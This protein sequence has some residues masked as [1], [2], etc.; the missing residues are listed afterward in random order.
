MELH[1]GS[2]AICRVKQISIAGRGGTEPRHT[3]GPAILGTEGLD[4]GVSQRIGAQGAPPR[5][6]T[7]GCDGYSPVAG[8]GAGPEGNPAIAIRHEVRRAGEPSVRVTHVP[9]AAPRREFDRPVPPPVG[10]LIERIVAAATH[11]AVAHVHPA[12]RPTAVRVEHPDQHL[13]ALL[14]EVDLPA[15]VRSAIRGSVDRRGAGAEITG[16]NPAVVLV[17]P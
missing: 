17:Y 4:G 9:P 5:T 10:G 12:E 6:A 13:P 3:G 8:T 1:P 7:V 2:T 16:A 11:G 14:M 15:P